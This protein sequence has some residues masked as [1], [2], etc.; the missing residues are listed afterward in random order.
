[1]CMNCGCGKPDDRHGRTENLIAGDIRAAAQANGQS[2]QETARN[3]LAAFEQLERQ[4]MA[5]S[6]ADKAAPGTGLHEPAG[7]TGARPGARGTPE[8]ES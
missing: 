1:M 8:S 3:I 2:L 5:A 7:A 6:P 4:G